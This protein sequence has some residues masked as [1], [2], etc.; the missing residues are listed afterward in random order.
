MARTSEEL[1]EELALDDC[2]DEDDDEPLEG[3]EDSGL[4]DDSDELELFE[5]LLDDSDDAELLDDSS[6]RLDAL[7]GLVD[8][9]DSDRLELLDSD[10]LDDDEDDEPDDSLESEDDELLDELSSSSSCT[11]NVSGN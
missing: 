8:W 6:E 9:L 4:L 5:E 7:D 2:D 3:D 1:E 11:L 10:G